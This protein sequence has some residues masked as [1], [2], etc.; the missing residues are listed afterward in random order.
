MIILLMGPTG[1]GKTTIGEMLARE[2]GWK[3]ADL[4]EPED[5]VVVDVAPAPAEIAAEIVKR[6][7]IS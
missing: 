1:S 4:E 3:F 5:A 7:G 2:L 6:L